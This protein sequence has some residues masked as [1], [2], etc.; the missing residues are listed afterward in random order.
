MLHLRTATHDAW[1][2]EVIDDLP[3]LLVDH[4]HCEKKAA[5]TA[6]TMLFRYPDCE[7]IQAPL[8][9]LAREELEHFEL[10]LRACRDRGVTFG[11]LGPS[12]YAGKLLAALS[13]SEPVRL[14][15]TIL[16]CALI[17]ARSCERMK[18]LS[19]GLPDASLRALYSSL[20]ATEARHHQL[21]LDLATTLVGRDSARGRLDVLA[22]HEADVI[23]QCSP[24][25]RMHS[26]PLPQR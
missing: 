23:S 17:E 13:A 25:V 4:A 3:T 10:M 1:L 11:R 8:S 16:C 2:Q 24:A 20:L 22:A 12:A 9:E 18:I 15:D 14:V 26:G 7:P 5:S 19:V 6:L 21:Y